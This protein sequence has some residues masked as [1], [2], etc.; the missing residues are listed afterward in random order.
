MVAIALYRALLCQCRAVPTTEESRN[1]LQNIVRNRFRANRDLRGS[2]RIK[3]SF[4]AGYTAIG[5]LDGSV[6]GNNESTTLIKDYLSDVPARLKIPPKRALPPQPELP[7]E[8]FEP[9]PEHKF[10]NVFPRPAV[11]GR[12]KIPFL[13]SANHFP[14][15]R[16]KK[17]QP[18]NVSRVIRNLIEQRF[19]RF[20]RR[21][22]LEDYFI[23][24]AKYE[25]QWEALLVKE[26]G[27]LNV[28]DDRD[29]LWVT[30]MWESQREVS[31]LISEMD[32]RSEKLGRKMLDV[33]NKEKEWAAKEDEENKRVKWAQHL[34][35][36]FGNGKDTA[37]QIEE[38][39]F[40]KAG[41]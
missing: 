16:Y 19:K 25:D 28:F 38:D 33:V 20:E 41:M 31:R 10:F 15:V 24:L 13:V 29:D 35:K 30:P 11:E 23:P 12:R 26:F 2:R 27:E 36:K 6:A 14:F 34:A 3:L 7:R 4:T 17:P 40:T 1:A 22:A 5:H 39:A 8:L 21:Y 18:A 37:D 9:P 32:R